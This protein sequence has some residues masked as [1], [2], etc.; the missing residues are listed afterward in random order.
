MTPEVAVRTVLANDAG[1]QALVAARV[2]QLKLPQSVTLPAVRVQLVDEPRAYH[3]RGEDALTAARVQV[4]TF[5][6][7]KS[8]EDPYDI[9][10]TVADAV[11]AALVGAAKTDVGGVRHFSAVYELMRRPMY[12]AEDL[13]EVR[14]LQDF[15][16]WSVPIEGS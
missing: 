8:G 11:H 16:I 14:V 12:D 7:E 2:Y 9:A 3:F 15:W 1:V 4:D 6:S 10:T 5:A 13:R